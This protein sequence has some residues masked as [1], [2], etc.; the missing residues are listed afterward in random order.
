MKK[1]Y[2]ILSIAL[3]LLASVYYYSINS[4]STQG[5]VVNQAGDSRPGE[6]NTASDTEIAVVVARPVNKK[7]KPPISAEKSAT[8]VENDE[9]ENIILDL[10]DLALD[11]D[12]DST[13]KL[14]QKRVACRDSWIA[15]YNARRQSEFF[16]ESS[17]SAELTEL[18][19]SNHFVEAAESRKYDCE[20]LYAVNTEDPR[21]VDELEKTNKR[22]LNRLEDKAEQGNA[23]ARYL[24]AMWRPSDREAFLIGPP[25]IDYEERAMRY[26]LENKA[27]NPQLALLALGK[28]YSGEGYFTPEH[29]TLGTA[30]LMAAGICGFTHPVLAMELGMY[31]AAKKHLDAVSGGESTPNEQIAQQAELIAVDFCPEQIIH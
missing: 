13:I 12:L 22:M 29:R 16:R 18:V 21:G 14:Q 28:S 2:L 15:E 31:A 17:G 27:D 9:S 5:G 8:A 3:L 6:P 30:Y 23:M 7:V 11:G 10:F 4:A 25:L 24:Y 20:L 26:T 19:E 1:T